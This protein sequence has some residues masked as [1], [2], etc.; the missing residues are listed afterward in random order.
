[1]SLYIGSKLELGDQSLIDSGVVRSRNVRWTTVRAS[2]G[3]WT[4]EAE[5]PAGSRGPHQGVK[6][7]EA[8]NVLVLVHP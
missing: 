5:L 7:P 3:I 8:E 1:M 4:P 2:K 6:L